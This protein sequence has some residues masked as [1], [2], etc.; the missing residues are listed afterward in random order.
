[1]PY[2][3]GIM[4]LDLIAQFSAIF[5]PQKA[6]LHTC[7][8]GAGLVSFSVHFLVQSIAL[9][10]SPVEEVY[11]LGKSFKVRCFRGKYL[12]PMYDLRLFTK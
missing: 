5:S 12:I 11:I 9:L 2:L 10:N 3:W 7:R 1:M 4:S 8:W 6:R